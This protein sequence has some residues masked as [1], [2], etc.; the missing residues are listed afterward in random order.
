MV[1]E[2]D[3]H[4]FDTRRTGEARNLSLHH[5]LVLLMIIILA[6]TLFLFLPHTASAEEVTWGNTIISGTEQYSN[7]TIN[8]DGNL[9]VE[10]DGLPIFN[11]SILVVYAT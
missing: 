7:L 8:L 11:D 10:P 5:L 3:I 2:E 9:T 4:G 6:A 1:G